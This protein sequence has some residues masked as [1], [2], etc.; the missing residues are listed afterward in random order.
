MWNYLQARW[1][2]LIFRL[3]FYFLISI[4]ALVVV[5]GISFAQRLKPHV[6]NE[7]LP[8]V[9]RYIEYLIDDIGDP[10]DLA[11]AAQLADELPFEIRIEGKAVNWASNPRLKAISN[12][13]FEPA[14]GPYSNVYLSHHRRNQY[15]L[16]KKQGYQYMFAVDNSFRQRSE[17]RHW[18]LLLALGSILLLLYFVIRRM[19]RPI[20]EISTQVRKIGEG[21]LA[22]TAVV[23]GKGEVALLSAGINRMAEQIKS[24]LES[25]SGLLLAISHELR[26]PL[27]RMRVNLELLDESETQQQLIDDIREMETLVAAILESER[28]GN[29]HA[30]LNL[31]RCELYALV[32]EVVHSHPCRNRIKTSM[33]PLELEVDQLRLK[34]LIKNLLDNACHYSSDVDSLVELNLR[35]DQKTVTIEVVD[36]GMGIATEDIPHL[37]EAFYR[38]DRARQRDTGG[39]GLGLYLCKL[40]AEAHGGRIV[41][42]SEP[43]TGTRVIVEI[44]L[45]NS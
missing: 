22:Q 20:G 44:P 42:E 37:T 7:I 6:Q 3:L 31:V 45:D 15:L 11:V 34:L 32:E 23:K 27:T 8:N 26:S 30:P 1:Q 24:M 36:H 5:L 10:P 39:Y 17:R 38:P 16:I 28:L 9:E 2:S 12:Y 21:D 19:F 4:L 41:I 43:G 33:S 25:K 13:D 35:H 14:P 40:I 29:G 18:V